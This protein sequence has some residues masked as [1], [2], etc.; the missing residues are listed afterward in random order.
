MHIQKKLSC[1]KV[2]KNHF[3]L[4]LKIII[5]F[6]KLIVNAKKF[7]NPLFRWDMLNRKES[8]GDAVQLV[9]Q[10]APIPRAR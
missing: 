7:P 9:P 5:L 2:S 6:E 1:Q 8:H 10:Q 3:F 4:N